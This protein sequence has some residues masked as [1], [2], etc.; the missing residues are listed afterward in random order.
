LFDSLE[1]RA[2][3]DGF[4]ESIELAWWGVLGEGPVRDGRLDVWGCRLSSTGGEERDKKERS[5][6]L[7][8]RLR[9][10]GWLWFPG[11]F[12][13]DS[14]LCVVIGGGMR[15]FEEEGQ[16]EVGNG[17]GLG[18]RCRLRDQKEPLRERGAL[19]TSVSFSFSFVFGSPAK[20]KKLDEPKDM[21]RIRR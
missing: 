10:R 18:T 2:F 14:D 11:R 21:P 17:S 8:E 19:L 5:D 12:T 4:E 15:E 7:R 3:G 16:E 6:K 9:G 1:Y 20:L 13:G